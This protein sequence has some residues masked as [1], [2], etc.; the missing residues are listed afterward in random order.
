LIYFAGTERISALSLSKSGISERSGFTDNQKTA[1]KLDGFP[2][3]AININ[4]YLKGKNFDTFVRGI[5][6]KKTGSIVKIYSN[7]SGK[8][9]GLKY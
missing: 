1:N 9:G 4:S 5:D 7:G 6:V 3:K 8:F 2:I